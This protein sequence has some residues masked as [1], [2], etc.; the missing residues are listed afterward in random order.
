MNKVKAVVL[1]G[2]PKKG[3]STSRSLAEHLAIGLMNKDVD[4]KI[5]HVSE[6]IG[7]PTKWRELL[8]RCHDADILALSAPLYVDSLPSELMAWMETMGEKGEE[9]MNGKR[10]IAMVQCG[11]PDVGQTAVAID[12]LKNFS[13][14][15]GYGWIGALQM[16]MGPV[17]DGKTL[18]EVKG[19]ARHAIK[20]LDLVVASLANGKEV[21]PE[22]LIEMQIKPLP[23][24]LYLMLANRMWRRRAKEN[25]VRYKLMERP[26]RF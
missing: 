24:F 6:S 8:D 2:S 15:M 1:I 12:I 25:G 16:P 4:V 13:D 7:H 14:R 26:Y 19:A 5:Y 23:V 11:F 18:S 10:F 21:P 20:A 9:M 22:A 3:V 17:I